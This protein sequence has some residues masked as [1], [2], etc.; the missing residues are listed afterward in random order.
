M[1]LSQTLLLPLLL[2]C[3]LN[4]GC[5]EDPLQ[6]SANASPSATALAPP[7]NAQAPAKPTDVQS[8]LNLLTGNGSKTWQVTKRSED[9]KDAS[10]DCFL[11]DQLKIF[12]KN[13]IEFKTGKSLCRYDGA[14]VKDRLGGWQMTD[15]LNLFLRVS[16]E[17][18]YELKIVSLNANQMEV[19][20]ISDNGKRVRESYMAIDLGENAAPTPAPLGSNIGQPPALPPP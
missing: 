15:G 3:L 19:S 9:E 12:R 16:P 10:Q 6:P 4:T 8:L 13:T 14:A 2:V 5:E 1:R 20:Y 17:Q 7:V 11:D 18:P